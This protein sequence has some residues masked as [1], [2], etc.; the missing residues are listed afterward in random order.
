IN[1]VR[2]EL[3]QLRILITDCTD[4][5]QCRIDNALQTIAEIQLCEPQQDPIS[6]DEFSKLT[7]ESSQQAVGLITKQA[8]LCEKAVRYL[9]E[10]L[11]KRLKPHEQVQI[12]ESDSEYYDCALKSAMNTKGHVTRCNDCQPCAFFNFLTIYWNKNIDAIVQC[13]RSS[14]ET[15]RKRLQQPV[16]Y[17]GEEVIRDQVRNPLF[18]TDI[19]LSIP[20]VL[21]KPSL[22]D[23]QSQ[24]NKSANTMLKI[25]QDIPE[26]Y[27][28]QKL[29]E[30]TIKEI[31]KQALDE[32][33]DVKLAVQ[34][35]APKPLHK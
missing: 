1:N 4:I 26:W 25:G 32:G 34:A 19:V 8:S 11:K 3:D 6:L 7:D 22:D 9:L 13:T 16:R 30:I 18:R 2:L 27:H 24:L 10:V 28:A 20:N 12:K 33:E 14:L 35:K 29:R 15:I 31:E 23:M 21:V 17:V 5:L